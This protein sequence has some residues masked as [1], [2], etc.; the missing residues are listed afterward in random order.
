VLVG[1][2]AVRRRDCLDV[3]SDYCVTAAADDADD[4]DTSTVQASRYDENAATH[5]SSN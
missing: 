5:Q 3:T 2:R 1:L 4:D